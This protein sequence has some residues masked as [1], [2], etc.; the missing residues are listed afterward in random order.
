MP[1]GGPVMDDDQSPLPASFL[2]L[3]LAP[4]RVR[5]S[6]P[7]AVIAARYELCEDMAQML[8]EPART[9]L[10]ALSITE[11][12]V[13]ERIERG[14]LADH[15]VVDAAEA[16]WVVCRLAELLEWPMPQ[17]VPPAPLPEGEGSVEA[18]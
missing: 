9:T 18:L 6:A 5:P 11:A 12:L 4:G 3:Y 16:R 7:R 13:L 15:A 14:L 10:F 17:A 2:A 8:A 1:R